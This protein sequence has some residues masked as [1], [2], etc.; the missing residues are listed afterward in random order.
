MGTLYQ[1]SAWHCKVE[2]NKAFSMVKGKE[3]PFHRLYN[4]LT[5]NLFRSI[6][7]SKLWKWK[8]WSNISIVCFLERQFL[9]EILLHWNLI[10]MCSQVI[11]VQIKYISYE[12][13]LD[14]YRMSVVIISYKTS[15]DAQNLSAP[16]KIMICVCI[17]FPL[18]IIIRASHI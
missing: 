7:Y 4:S 1:H 5:L 16:I 17:I 6:H 11:E 8:T 15:L 3:T 14:G 12:V 18:S 10:A 2:Y 9:G 13:S